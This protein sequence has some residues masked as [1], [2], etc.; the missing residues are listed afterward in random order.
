[1]LDITINKDA[2]R[3]GSRFAITFQR[4]L[5]ITDDGRTY[6]VG[7]TSPMVTANEGIN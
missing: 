6:P 3:V 1:M 2:V 4:T 5:R 7:A